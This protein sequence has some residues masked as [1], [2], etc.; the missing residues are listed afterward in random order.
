VLNDAA[1][2]LAELKGFNKDA[3]NP[4]YIKKLQEKIMPDPD[5][6][7][8]RAKS[9]SYAVQFL[10]M[11]VRAMYDYNKVYLETKPLREKLAATQSLL[12]EKSQ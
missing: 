3:I 7:L 12:A 10:Y 1:V 2:L 11:W 8:D 9:C 5:F 4:A 6:T